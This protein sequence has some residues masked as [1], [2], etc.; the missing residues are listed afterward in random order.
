MLG[1]LAGGVLSFFLGLAGE[2]G[3]LGLFF[4]LFFFVCV[5]GKV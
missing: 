5:Q 1:W 4:F 2:D 3:G